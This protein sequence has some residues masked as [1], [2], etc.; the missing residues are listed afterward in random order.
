MFACLVVPTVMMLP[1]IHEKTYQSAG[2]LDTTRV[3]VAEYARTQPEVVLHYLRLC[4]VPTGLNIDYAWPVAPAWN[5]PATLGIGLLAFA[6]VAATRFSPALGF[7]GGWWFVILAPTSSVAPIVDLAFEHRTYLPSIAP[8]ALAVG[9]VYV[10]VGRGGARCGCEPETT[11]S[12]RGALLAVAV[13][14]LTTLTLLRNY[15]Y[16]SEEALW[17]DVARKAPHNPRAHYN[18]GVY[19]QIAGST[20]E[21]DAAIVEYHE[22]LR[23]DP[24]YADAYLNLGN[25]AAWRKQWP[26]A[27]RYYAKLLELRPGDAAA[28]TGLDEARKN[29]AGESPP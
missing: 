26:D 24:K 19:L 15:D 28:Q 10:V 22:T 20:E 25:L 1:M 4:F 3:T 18:H 29:Q 2:I 5:V 23:L 27:G 8:I 16:R 13:A 21:I 7:L 12:V 17:G 6:T 9:C 14:A 11:A